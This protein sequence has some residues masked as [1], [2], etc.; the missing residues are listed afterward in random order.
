MTLEQNL[1]EVQPILEPKPVFE[2]I[3]RDAQDEGFPAFLGWQTAFDD[4]TYGYVIQAPG[5]RRVVAV[6]ERL[7]VGEDTRW[8][9]QAFR[10]R[11]DDD[12]SPTYLEACQQML[13]ETEENAVDQRYVKDIIRKL[14]MGYKMVV[15]YPDP[16]SLF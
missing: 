3:L 13:A 9:A 4:T 7:S 14:Y 16:H 11:R 12:S 5:T 15:P 6:I 1:V 8:Q 10:A 2:A